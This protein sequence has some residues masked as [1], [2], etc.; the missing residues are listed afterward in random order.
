MRKTLAEWEAVA[1]QYSP[2]VRL[3]SS[4][5]DHEFWKDQFQPASVDW[6]IERCWL[7]DRK[8]PTFRLPADPQDVLKVAD[9]ASHPGAQFYL[10]VRDDAAR[11][12]DVASAV[13][14]VH[15]RPSPG[16]LNCVDLQYWVLYPYSGGMGGFFGPSR[17]GLGGQHEGDWEHVTV[18]LADEAGALTLQAIFFAA[19]GAAEGAWMV[20]PAP[21]PE[22]GRYALVPGTTHP[23]VYSSYHSHA[24]YEVGGLNRRVWNWFGWIDDLALGGLDFGPGRAVVAAIGAD[25][26]TSGEPYLAEW[27][28]FEGRYG[29]DSDSPRGPH[30]QNAWDDDGDNGYFTRLEVAARLGTQW[31]SGRG[32]TDVAVGQLDHQAVV[33]LTRN[34]GDGARFFIYGERAD[35]IVELAAGGSGWGSG[36]GATA[37]AFGALGSEQ[38]MAVG[39]DAGDGARFEVYTYDGSALVR[40]TSG[41]EEWG[42]GHAVTGLAFGRWGQQDVLAVSRTGDGARV[43]V[44]AWDASANAFV[45]LTNAGSDWGDGRDA[46]AV[47]LGLLDDQPVVG[48]TRSQG[49]GA[50]F[51]IYRYEAPYLITLGAGGADWGASREATSIAFGVIGGQQVVG[52]T[53]NAG[54]HERFFVYS[55]DASAATFEPMV[56][57][58]GDW[59][60]GRGA[61]DIAFG[62]VNGATAVGVTRTAGDHGEAFYGVYDVEAHELV[63]FAVE[64]VD[65]GSGRDA[66]ATAFGMLGGELVVCL[67]RNAGDHDRGF[68]LRWQ[69][70][71]PEAGVS[72]RAHTA[73]VA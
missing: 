64:G 58:G 31:G 21:A 16:I 51:E 59:G 38:V 6:Y 54:D 41:G 12:G 43:I 45:E 13:C 61:T 50:R 10:T 2:V 67:A 72:E 8:D 3:T 70:A 26:M 65:W 49:G 60:D 47:A 30:L 14:Y 56:S 29:R 48:V 63:E 44:Y 18:R 20:K 69:R 19:H 71:A 15:V 32:A 22:P 34:A 5:W 17:K 37:V 11:R 46:T 57:G 42:D 28:K 55:F 35:E 53:R 33:G 9:V 25:V 7:L 1:A 39:R 73:A 36:R 68:V 66:T 23:I 24:S 52:V 4:K 40:R 62:P 27:L